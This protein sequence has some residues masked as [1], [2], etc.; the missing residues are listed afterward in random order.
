VSARTVACRQRRDHLPILERGG[1]NHRG[2]DSDQRN[3]ATPKKY[4]GTGS[5]GRSKQ[6]LLEAIGATLVAHACIP[7]VIFAAVLTGIALWGTAAMTRLSA[8]FVGWPILSF[9]AHR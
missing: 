6:R 7:A 3:S 2:P 5:S 1:K 8:A 4:G 9:W